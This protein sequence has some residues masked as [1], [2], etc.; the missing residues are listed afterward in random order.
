MDRISAATRRRTMMM[1]NVHRRSKETKI[2]MNSIP[3]WREV[4]QELRWR[5]CENIL[6]LPVTTNPFYLRLIKSPCNCCRRVI[7]IISGEWEHSKR[8][9]LFFH[10]SVGDAIIFIRFYFLVLIMWI[11]RRFSLFLKRNYDGIY[12]TEMRKFFNENLP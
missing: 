10:L 12:A 1:T 2:E 4:R 11:L 8:Y 5:I 9:F 3:I 6:T 7:N